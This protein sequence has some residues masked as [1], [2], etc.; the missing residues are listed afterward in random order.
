MSD[1]R[2]VDEVPSTA[3][4]LTVTLDGGKQVSL[5]YGLQVEFLDRKNNRDNFR[6]LEGV[7]KGLLA[8]VIAKGADASYLVSSIR[9]LP[10]GAVYFDSKSQR[11][12]F[13]TRG[14]V[15]A[16]SGSGTG[17]ENGRPV[18]YT[19]VPKGVYDLAIP[20]F[21]SAQTRSQYGVWTKYHKTWFRIGT[22]LSGSRFLHAGQISDGC[23]TVRQFLYDGRQGV[24]MPSG[25][26]DL[27]HVAGSSNQGLIGLPLASAPAPVI[28]FD[29]IYRYLILRR[30]NDQAVG[31][32]YVTDTGAF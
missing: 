30:L 7:N 6:I 18:T 9:H 25:F 8:S 32:L 17:N 12:K 13:G 5:P 15:N 21:P 2:Y 26:A 24:A 19:P 28:S 22:N 16:F 4:W 27:P 10:P 11:L 20:A 29:E 3:N 31:K 14:P 23:V 1:I